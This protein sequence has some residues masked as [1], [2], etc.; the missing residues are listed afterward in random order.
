M[1]SDQAISVP[2]LK[3]VKNEHLHAGSCTVSTS[4][5][6]GT[7]METAQGNDAARWGEGC[8]GQ[9]QG[10]FGRSCDVSKGVLTLAWDPAEPSV[11]SSLLHEPHFTFK[12]KH[13]LSAHFK[14]PETL[15]SS[16]SLS[17]P[18]A[19]PSVC[20]WCFRLLVFRSLQPVLFLLIPAAKLGGSRFKFQQ[21]SQR[22]IM[23]F[24]TLC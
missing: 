16:P 6:G 14:S 21:G 11:L 9:P 8:Y 23:L 18:L 3:D 19:P 10:L 7:V 17:V 15:T 12:N 4:G 13:K 22:R 20:L 24:C 2:K 5:Q 1:V